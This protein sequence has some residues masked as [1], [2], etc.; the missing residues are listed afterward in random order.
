MTMLTPNPGVLA[1]DATPPNGVATY[2]PLFIRLAW[3]CASTFRVTDYLGGCNGARIQ[4]TPQS[5]WPVNV[6]LDKALLLLKP[7]KDKYGDSL[8]YSDLIV[9]AANV[10][11]ENAGGRKMTFCGGRTDA[12]DGTYFS[13]TLLTN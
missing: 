10:A 9:L 6:A 7:V 2:G 8:S 3:Q 1:P 5:A 4:F 13:L 12:T 11:I